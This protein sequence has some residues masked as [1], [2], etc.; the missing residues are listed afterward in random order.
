MTGDNE[1]NNLIKNELKLYS[2]KE[3]NKNMIFL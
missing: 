2:N 1:F 3:S